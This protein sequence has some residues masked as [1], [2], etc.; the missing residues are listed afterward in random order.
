MM[1]DFTIFFGLWCLGC[2][3]ATGVALVIMWA[4][5]LFV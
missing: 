2:L 3:T 4:E 5:G 1:R